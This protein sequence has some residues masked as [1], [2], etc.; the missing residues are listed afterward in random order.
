[1][2][3]GLA[4]AHETCHAPGEALRPGPREQLVSL[5]PASAGGGTIGAASMLGTEIVWCLAPAAWSPS[6]PRV[7]TS[8]GLGMDTAPRDR[9]TRQASGLFTAHGPAATLHPG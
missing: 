7:A 1:M 9:H 2:S 6:K 5:W 4:D 8:V 3:Q